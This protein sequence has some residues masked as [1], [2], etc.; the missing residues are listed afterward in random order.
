MFCPKCGTQINE[1]TGFCPNCGAEIPKIDNLQVAAEELENNV[2]SINNEVGEKVADVPV[3]TP[4]EDDIPTFAP[5]VE[6]TPQFSGPACFHHEFEP[7]AGTCARCGKYICRDCI[8]AYTVASG[9]F[10]NQP[11][12]YDC[13][14]ELVSENVELLKQQKKD[15]TKMFI[16]TGLG[17]L[18]GACIGAAG[19]VVGALI[20][21]L[22]GGALWTAIKAI[23]RCFKNIWDS[24]TSGGAVVSILILLKD[25]VICAIITIKKVVQCIIHLTRTSK[26]IEEDTQALAEMKDYMEY[27]QVISRNKGVDLE[28]L[29]GQGSELYNNS[30]AQMVSTQ[31]EEA[32]DAHLRQAATRI[33]E[34]GEIIRNFDA[35]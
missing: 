11:L 8:E 23:G 25:L 12:C 2:I 27:T 35:A 21:F 9:E 3:F 7:A 24:G 18:V 30:Y 31:G 33:A 19:G 20:G 34:N 28:T 15:I 22:V 14:Q 32:A 5:P 4:P 26:F 13:C 10:E 16:L 6:T 17:M 29:M 1:G